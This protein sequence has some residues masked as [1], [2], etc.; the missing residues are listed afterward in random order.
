[1]SSVVLGCDGIVLGCDGIVLG[2]DGIVLGSIVVL[3][4]IV[5]GVV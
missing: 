4:S 5:L 2:C 1:M 3:W